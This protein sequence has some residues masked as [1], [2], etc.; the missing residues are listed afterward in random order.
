MLFC[1]PKYKK[2]LVHNLR[3]FLVS[4][5]DN[6][7]EI[8]IWSPVDEAYDEKST[9][10]MSSLLGRILDDDD[11][12]RVKMTTNVNMNVLRIRAN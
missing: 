11:K 7:W 5:N 6:N 8:L 4:L 12:V 2:A 9:H 10:D 3:D 1:D